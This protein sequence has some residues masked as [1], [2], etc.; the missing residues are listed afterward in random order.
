MY[1]AMQL[2]RRKDRRKVTS[3]MSSTQGTLNKSMRRLFVTDRS[4]K[5][6]FLV[7]TGADTGFGFAGHV[8]RQT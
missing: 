2:G 1:L 6:K 7:D 8:R 5:M 3:G 4:S